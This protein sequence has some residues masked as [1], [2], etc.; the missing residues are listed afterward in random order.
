MLPA[1]DRLIL[2]LPI[3]SNHE[4]P[5]LREKV[6]PEYLPASMACRSP[7]AAVIPSHFPTDQPQPRGSRRRDCRTLQPC[8]HRPGANPESHPGPDADRCRNEEAM[9]MKDRLCPLLRQFQEIPRVRDVRFA[10]MQMR[11]TAPDAG[12]P[13]LPACPAVDPGGNYTVVPVVAP[14]IQ[15]VCELIQARSWQCLR[16]QKHGPAYSRYAYREVRPASAVRHQPPA[17]SNTSRPPDHCPC[18]RQKDQTD[19]RHRTDEHPIPCQSCPPPPT[20]P[21]DPTG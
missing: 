7:H 13:G 12:K 2:K 16:L 14:R 5:G 19:C 11:E 20:R 18:A 4:Y 9:D 21:T 17:L 1:H 6:Y 3:H 8:G 10:A 15:F